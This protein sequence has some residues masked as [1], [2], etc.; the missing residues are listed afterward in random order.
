MPSKSGSNSY[1][2][3]S[4]QRVGPH[5][6]PLRRKDDDRSTRRLLVACV[7]PFRRDRYGCLLTSYIV[8]RVEL[9]VQSPASRRKVVPQHWLH[10]GRAK[11]TSPH[12]KCPGL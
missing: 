4:R 9:R 3:L 6:L 5:V 12:D 2:R 8:L 1:A 7:A 11:A 10:S